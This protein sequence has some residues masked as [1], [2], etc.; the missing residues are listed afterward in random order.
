M[1]GKRTRSCEATLILKKMLAW[2]L[3]YETNHAMQTVLTKTCS[4]F[5]P[6]D[7]N[8][9]LQVSHS[10]IASIHGI[11]G[12]AQALATFAN[13]T[14]TCPRWRVMNAVLKSAGGAVTIIS[15]A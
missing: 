12:T 15:E 5:I 7:P 14:H 6:S 8:T 4:L 3:D 2:K 11:S 13:G 1:R 9:S 10:S